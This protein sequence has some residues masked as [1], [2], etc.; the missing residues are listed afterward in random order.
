MTNTAFEEIQQLGPEQPER[1]YRNIQESMTM[2]IIRRFLRHRLAVSGLIVLILLIAGALLAPNY[3]YDP[4][5]INLRARLEPPSLEHLM[6]TDDL[7]RDMLARVLYGG[8]VSLTV[9]LLATSLSLVLGT[10]VG[11]LAGFYGRW[12]DSLLMR[13]TDMFLSFPSLFVLI[14]LGAMLRDTELAAFRGG[15]FVIVAA[16]ALLSWMTTARLVRATVLSLKESGYVEAAIAAGSTNRRLVMVHI[17]PNALGPII[18][19]GALQTAYSILTES[20]LSY[21]GFGIQPPTPTWGNM[22]NGAQTY[23]T[24]NPWLAIF[25][26]LMIFITVL[27]V[28]FIGDGLRDAFDPRVIFKGK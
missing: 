4:E 19:Q 2:R 14:M 3:R 21:L 24:R 16:I 25:P 13:G 18:V 15:L 23:M 8:R 22:L 1:A 26:G 10:L 6:G 5:K 28:N 17:L 9:G 27:S 11:L 20:G 12:I 7:G